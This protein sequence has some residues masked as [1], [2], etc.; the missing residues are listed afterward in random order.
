MDAKHP[1]IEV[2]RPVK[3]LVCAAKRSM[4]NGWLRQLRHLRS[5][6]LLR[7]PLINKALCLYNS[8]DKCKII[9]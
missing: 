6:F 2:K 7:K 1:I 9:P 4:P 8:I 3:R 5:V